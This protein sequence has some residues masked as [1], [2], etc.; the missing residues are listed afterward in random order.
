M[1]SWRLRGTGLVIAALILAVVGVT[2]MAVGAAS[3]HTAGTAAPPYESIKASHEPTAALSGT[4]LIAVIGLGIGAI[5]ML[6]A[7]IAAW[8][9][10]KTFKLAKEHQ[11][12]SGT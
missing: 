2:L 4:D 12:S 11:K 8:I 6:A 1:K 7:V 5:S 3:L 9:A 10:W